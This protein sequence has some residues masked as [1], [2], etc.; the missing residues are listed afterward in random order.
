[1]RFPGR[2]ISSSVVVDSIENGHFDIHCHQKIHNGRYESLIPLPVGI[3]HGKTGQ[4]ADHHTSIFTV[5]KGRSLTTCP[6][7]SN[8]SR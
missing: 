8:S 3:I 2:D 6:P 1:M 5:L 7:P 4:R